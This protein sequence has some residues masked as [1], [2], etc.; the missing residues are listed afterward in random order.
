MVDDRQPAGALAR[1]RGAVSWLALAAAFALAAVMLVPAA[2]GYQRY[3]VTG[4]SMTGSIDRGSVVFD[5]PVPVGDLHVGDVI[6]YRP[7]PGAHVIGLVTH[8]IVWAGHDPHGAP[9]FRTKGDF[10]ESADSWQF[11]LH[12]PT[13][14]KVVA[15][16][17]LI[18][19]VLAGL[20]DRRLRMFVIGIPAL[21]IG[22]A[23]AIRLWRDP[24]EALA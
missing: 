9:S 8:R 2:F 24:E 7:P 12:A 19:Y 1:T 13:Q 20:G 5:K 4:G 17:P 21:L 14:A 15:Q 22:I 3:V 23:V 6:T 16:I 18:G 11:T 10:N